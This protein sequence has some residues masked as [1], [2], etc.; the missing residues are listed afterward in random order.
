VDPGPHVIGWVALV[1]IGRDFLWGL[2][3]RAGESA[4]KKDSPRV[5]Q[6]RFRILSQLLRPFASEL[7]TPLCIHALPLSAAVVVMASL[8][9]LERF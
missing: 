5:K 1:C 8:V 3:A 4:L 6:L 7:S 2:E 9:H